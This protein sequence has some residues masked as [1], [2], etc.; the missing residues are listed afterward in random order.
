MVPSLHD[1]IQSAIIASPPADRAMTSTCD[2][3]SSRPAEAIL[4]LGGSPGTMTAMTELSAR[5][6]SNA[7]TQSEIHS[8]AAWKGRMAGD[9]LEWLLA[10]T[11]VGSKAQG[12]VPCNQ[13]PVPAMPEDDWTSTSA[14]RGP[15]AARHTMMPCCHGVH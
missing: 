10:G 3:A 4:A 12:T 2:C 13:T 7:T 6:H 15:T 14:S 1:G 11:T 9:V 8:G 5:R